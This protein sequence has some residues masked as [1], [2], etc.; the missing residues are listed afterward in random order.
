M[1]REHAVSDDKL[2]RPTTATAAN[3]T[4]LPLHPWRRVSRAPACTE[5]SKCRNKR[6]RLAW[7]MLSTPK[8]SMA[9][10]SELTTVCPYCGR[11]LQ[12][13]PSRWLGRGVFQC[14]QCGDFPDFRKPGMQLDPSSGAPRWRV[15]IVD[16]SDEH[17][18]LYAAMLGDT[19]TVVTAP[20]GPRALA[21]A[22]AQPPDVI[23]LDVLMPVMDGF[24]VCERLDAED[25]PP[26]AHAAGALGVLM[27]PCPLERLA[28]TL[29]SAVGSGANSPSPR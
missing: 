14:Q 5:L 1:S 3:F 29:E 22:K 10:S 7:L 17:R 25:V 27:K 12:W 4:M 8:S 13:M 23:L 11:A 6:A 21:L 28:L 9:S 26:R 2:S 20:N 24:E 16:D 15:L 18:E 19:M